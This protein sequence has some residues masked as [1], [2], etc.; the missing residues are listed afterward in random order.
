M[1]KECCVNK[2]TER[3]YWINKQLVKDNLEKGNNI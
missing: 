2:R 3:K 1:N